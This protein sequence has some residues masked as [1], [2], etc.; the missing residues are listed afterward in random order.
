M[1]KHVNQL[2]ERSRFVKI[3]LPLPALWLPECPSVAQIQ[4]QDKLS[5]PWPCQCRSRDRDAVAGIY[6]RRPLRIETPSR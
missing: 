3:E 4:G 1:W 5:A 6:E 2:T